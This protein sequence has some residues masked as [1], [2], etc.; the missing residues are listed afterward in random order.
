MA[1]KNMKTVCV[2]LTKEQDKWLEDTAAINGCT[3]SY[4]VRVAI[5]KF[6]ELIEGGADGNK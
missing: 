6:I 5:T 1:D 4:L 3:K 2:T